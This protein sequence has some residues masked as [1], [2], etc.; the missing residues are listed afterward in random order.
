MSGTWE[1]LKP[2]LERNY[3]PRTPGDKRSMPAISPAFYPPGMTRGRDN[4]A[5]VGLLIFDFDNAADEA[6]PGEFHLDSRTGGPTGRPKTQKVRIADPVTMADVMGT[7]ESFGIAAL[8]WTTWSATPQWEKF[9]VLIPLAR[10]VPVD[11]WERAS[12]LAVSRLGL[13]PFRRGLDA[14]VLHNPAALAF[15]PGSPDPATIRR[16]GTEGVP[17]HLTWDSLPA[18]P[19]QALAPWQAEAVAGRQAAR[20]RGDQWWTAYRVHGRPVDFQAL[21][22]AAILEARGIKVGPPRPFKSGTKRRACCPWAGE[23][24][25]GLDD[26]AAVLIHTP[27][28]WP[29]FKCMHSGHAHMSLRDVIEWAWGRP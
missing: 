13:D 24:S 2:I 18:A 14:P 23:H 1:Q 19:V 17:F 16:A 5:G 11:V 15:L 26:D 28:S 22:L 20:E 29:S 3:R 6:I 9:R 4:A 25:G 27:S 12:E 7:L 10:P 8:A 21:D